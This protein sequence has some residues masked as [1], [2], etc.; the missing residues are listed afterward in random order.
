ME[1]DLGAL[2]KRVSRESDRNNVFE[3]F[4]YRAGWLAGRLVGWLIGWL[5]GCWLAS[6][7]TGWLTNEIRATEYQPQDSSTEYQSWNFVSQNRSPETIHIQCSGVA[8]ARPPR[9]THLRGWATPPTHTL[10]ECRRMC[11]VSGLLVEYQCQILATIGLVPQK[12]NS[13]LLMPSTCSLIAF[14]DQPIFLFNRVVLLINRSY[15]Y[16]GE[17]AIN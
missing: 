9:P 2:Q 10:P 7:L 6:W 12:T 1:G 3:R 4:G 13:S 8:H 16:F 15:T 11:L 14:I 5:A 17:G